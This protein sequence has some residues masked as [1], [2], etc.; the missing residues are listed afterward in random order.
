M[1]IYIPDGRGLE[2]L[3]L[4]LLRIVPGASLNQAVLAIAPAEPSRSPSARP[5]A[6]GSEPGPAPPATNRASR[7]AGLEPTG[8]IGE[9][10][11]PF[12]RPDKAG[13]SN[14]IRTAIPAG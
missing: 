4:S 8:V 5:C 11:R 3:A 2:G 12:S 10:R 13:T 6:L 1:G 14:A 9:C 7:R